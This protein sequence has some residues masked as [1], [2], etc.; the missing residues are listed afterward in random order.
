MSAEKR[1]VHLLTERY[2]RVGGQG[3]P[4]RN[5]SKPVTVKFGLGLLQMDLDER[6]KIFSMSMWSKYVSFIHLYLNCIIYCETNLV[7]LCF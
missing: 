6:N 2:K 7:T 4:V 1:V 5:S 3:R